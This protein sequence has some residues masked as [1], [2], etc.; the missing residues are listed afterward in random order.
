MNS[1]TFNH[2]ISS[3]LKSLNKLLTEKGEEYA[4]G[5]RLSNFKDAA[6][7]NQCTEE[8][9]LWGYVTKH[10]IALKDFVKLIEDTPAQAPSSAQLLEKTGDIAIYMLL[11]EAIL[12][13]HGFVEAPDAETK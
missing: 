10:I 6:Q 11:L 5:D 3:R 1:S 2:I 13:E 12:I 4:H 8:T 7:L 9:V